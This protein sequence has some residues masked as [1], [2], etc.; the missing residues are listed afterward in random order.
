[1]KT[2]IVNLTLLVYA[3]WGDKRQPHMRLFKRQT[4]TVKLPEEYVSLTPVSKIWSTLET[5]ASSFSKMPPRLLIVNREILF[6]KPE[7]ILGDTRKDLRRNI[8]N[9]NYTYD[10]ANIPGLQTTAAFK[11]TL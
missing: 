7:N 10:S 5:C 9:K 1:M 11:Q 3:H 8:V 6:T 2:L 4:N